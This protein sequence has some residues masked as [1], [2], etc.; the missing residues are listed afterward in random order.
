MKKTE[1]LMNKILEEIERTGTIQIACDK[2]GVS[3]NTFY[4]WIKKDKQF[5][6]RARH[7]IALGVGYVNDVATSNVLSAIKA[8]DMKATIF[9][10]T[11][12]HPEFRR[13]YIHRIDS[14]DFLAHQRA[15]DDGERKVLM[16]RAMRDAE[17]R[18]SEEEIQEAV[19]KAK[20]FQKKWFKD[21]Q[22]IQRKAEK[23][24]EQW[25]TDY[26]DGHK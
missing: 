8:K 11:H 6:E 26:L 4:Q 25:K 22:N 12:R 13:P 2:N 7:S 21:D 19:K 15:I 23:L 10:L 18:K 3:R 16:E 20:E 5:S 24:F 1:A 9:W 17:T 14:D